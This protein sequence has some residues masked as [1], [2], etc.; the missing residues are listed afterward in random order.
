[1]NIGEFGACYTE[2]RLAVAWRPKLL[3]L[4][5][6]PR[7]STNTAILEKFIKFIH[8]YMALT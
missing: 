8:H 3:Q 2:S 5:P 7:T 4:L 6:A 1:M